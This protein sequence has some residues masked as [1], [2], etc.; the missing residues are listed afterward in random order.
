[1]CSGPIGFKISDS[2]KHLGSTN[3]LSLEYYASG[4]TTASSVWLG[5]IVQ[6][7]PDQQMRCYG[8]NDK[9]IKFHKPQLK[10]PRS[11]LYTG[12][13]TANS[14]LNS[15]V[16]HRLRAGWPQDSKSMCCFRKYVRTVSKCGL[17]SIRKQEWWYFYKMKQ[18]TVESQCTKQD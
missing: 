17:H 1:M 5:Q 6:I 9:I 7:E 12:S 13:G 15:K 11:L 2:G 3:Y 16:S 14:K 10:W 8:Y 18:R 4:T